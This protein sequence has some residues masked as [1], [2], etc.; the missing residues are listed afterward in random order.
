MTNDKVFG[1]EQTNFAGVSAR[2]VN[3]QRDGIS[4]NNQRWPNGLDS[5][6]TNEP[7]PGR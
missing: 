7:G 3:M 4:M 2:D 5:P 6:T 1:A